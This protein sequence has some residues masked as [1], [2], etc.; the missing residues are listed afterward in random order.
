LEGVTPATRVLVE[1]FQEVF[2][3]LVAEFDPIGDGFLNDGD[4]RQFLLQEF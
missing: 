1:E 3:V 4:F 2:P